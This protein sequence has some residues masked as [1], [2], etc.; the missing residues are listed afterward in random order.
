MRHAICAAI[1]WQKSTTT[2]NNNIEKTYSCSCCPSRSSTTMN[3]C[4]AFREPQPQDAHAVRHHDIY[5]Y[6]YHHH[7]SNNNRWQSFTSRTLMLSGTV[8]GGSSGSG[9]WSRGVK[10]FS[11]GLVYRRACAPQDELAPASEGAGSASILHAVRGRAQMRAL[12]N[13]RARRAS[14]NRCGAF[15]S[16]PW[17]VSSLF[18]RAGIA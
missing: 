17:H 12:P 10:G 18:P 1:E 2:T 14:R 16:S 13:G 15:G 8:C 5:Y 11:S 7:H 3:H 4:L 9:S 6:Y